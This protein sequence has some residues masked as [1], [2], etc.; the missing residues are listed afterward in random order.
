MAPNEPT[1]SSDCPLYSKQYMDRAINIICKLTYNIILDNSK[2]FHFTL[3]LC[4]DSFPFLYL[5]S[6]HLCTDD[7]TEVIH[8]SQVFIPHKQ[9]YSILLLNDF[10]LLFLCL[11]WNWYGPK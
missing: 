11:F 6:M 2:K 10:G 7:W 5:H 4:Y 9:N 8:N 3:S 1:K